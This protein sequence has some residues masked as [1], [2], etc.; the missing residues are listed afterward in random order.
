MKFS[1]LD[2]ICT[3]R[4]HIRGKKNLSCSSRVVF[5]VKNTKPTVK[6]FNRLTIFVL[7]HAILILKNVLYLNKLKNI[8][9]EIGLKLFN[10]HTS[11]GVQLS[12]MGPWCD[13][14]VAY[15]IRCKRYGRCA[16]YRHYFSYFYSEKYIINFTKNN[17]V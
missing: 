15:S 6:P 4:R 10:K 16:S 1:V 3:Q 12:Q 7:Y 9:L 5:C 13:A 8:I 2:F 11:P 17:C 14:T